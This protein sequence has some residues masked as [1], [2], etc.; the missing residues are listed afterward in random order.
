VQ[1]KYVALDVAS[2][3]IGTLLAKLKE[4]V[5]SVPS[6]RILVNNVGMNTSIPVEFVDMTDAEI[7]D[8]LQVNV[9][10]TTKLTK[11]CVPYLTKNKASAII[12]LSSISCIFASSPL[13]SV[14]AAT[15]S[16]DLNFSRSIG[17]ELKRFG[18]DVIALTPSFVASAMSGFRRTNMMV[19]SPTQT[20]RDTFP[21][22]GK[23]SEL[24]PFW[25]HD[26][27]RLASKFIP[28]S[29]SNP[30]YFKQMTSTR[31]RLLRKKN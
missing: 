11:L 13:M 21:K 2:K 25:S 30:L 17:V 28:E 24:T 7:D 15:K 5:E 26:L 12:N 1:T 16:Y 18:C 20:A 23:F 27:L 8:Q 9:V 6:F 19:S 14:Y 31:E 3:D 4:S 10:F 29:V 22:L